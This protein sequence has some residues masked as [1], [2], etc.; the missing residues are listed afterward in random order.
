MHGDG[1]GEEA[2]A[3]RG[4]RDRGSVRRLRGSH[5][6]HAALGTTAEC[7]NDVEG[8]PSGLGN[9]AG[10]PQTTRMAPRLREG[11]RRPGPAT[12]KFPEEAAALKGS[13]GEELRAGRQAV[14]LREEQV[15]KRGTGGSYFVRSPRT[16][17]P[18]APGHAAK[19]QEGS[20]R[21]RQAQEGS[22]RLQKARGN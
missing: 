12:Q 20:G 19:A 18:L 8:P 11:R 21:L 5:A 2:D 16:R 6:P 15:R 7:R 13:R 3:G 9:E 10:R 17:W 4:S 22:G 1:D 14:S